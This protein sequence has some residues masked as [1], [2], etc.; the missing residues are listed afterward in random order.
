MPRGRIWFITGTPGAG[1]TTLAHR[2]AARY[3]RPIL[4]TGDIARRI[5]PEALARGEWADPDKFR[6]AMAEAVSALEGPGAAP[7]YIVDGYPR[8]L[9]QFEE[10]R[11]L[12]EG[13]QPE[14]YVFFLNARP[15][16]EADRLLR[17]GRQDDRPEVIKARIDAQ[18]ADFETWVR[19]AVPWGQQIS[20]SN[21]TPDWIEET[22]RR[23]LDGERREV[24]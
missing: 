1:K 2:L 21:R 11:A 5:D 22:F 6:N 23:F 20:T 13:E 10:I 4:S 3:D 17:R 19:K 14:A 18:H 24:F 16:V 15:D 9:A 7:S 12:T 8:Y